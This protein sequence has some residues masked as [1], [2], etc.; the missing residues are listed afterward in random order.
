M[1]SLIC[2]IKK[3][4]KPVNITKMKQTHR[5][6][7]Q[8]SGYQWWGRGCIGVE[9]WEVQTIG[10]KMGYKDVLYNMGNITNIL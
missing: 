4:T 1:T 7:E 10:C 3:K 6:R 5:Y 2:G 8:T 9:E